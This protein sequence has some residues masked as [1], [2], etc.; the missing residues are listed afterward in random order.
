MNMIKIVFL[1]LVVL[2]FG[3]YFVSDSFAVNFRDSSGYTPSWAIDAGM[4]SALNTCLELSGDTSR[5]GNWCLEW[6]IYVLD[7]GADNFSM[8]N[9]SYNNFIPTEETTTNTNEV[10]SFVMDYPTGWHT[11]STAGTDT[12]AL[13]RAS[14]SIREEK[15]GAITVGKTIGKLPV[16][17]FSTLNAFTNSIENNCVNQ[18]DSK[19]DKF[20]LITSEIK[21]IN[22][23]PTYYVKYTSLASGIPTTFWIMSI[24]DGN[25]VWGVAAKSI[26]P[27]KWGS[28]IEESLETF[29]IITVSN[30]NAEIQNIS[31]N[32][33]ISSTSN[34]DTISIPVGTG[35]PGCE[36]NNRCY[37]PY[38][39]TISKGGTVTW[40]NDDTAAHTVT[41]GTPVEGPS[42]A[43]D[44]SLMMAGSTF[45]VTFDQSGE[46]PYF[47][48]VHPWMVGHIIV[49]TSTT[50]SKSTTTDT[51]TSTSV[52]KNQ[53]LETKSSIVQKLS[54]LLSNAGY[55][56]EDPT[57]VAVGDGIIKTG[58][59]VKDEFGESFGGINVW[60][61]NNYVT[62]VE[63]AT[64]HNNDFD[65]ASI[66]VIA[67]AG[68]VKTIMDPDDFDVDVFT[69]MYGE[70]ADDL[71]YD[72]NSVRT[73]SNGNRVEVNSI[74]ILE[75]V[76]GLTMVTFHVYYN[77]ENTST[78]LKTIQNTPEKTTT[79]SQKTIQTGEIKSE[80]S[81]SDD[82]ESN[83][84]DAALGAFIV[85]GIPAILIG[86]FIVRRKMKKSQER[87]AS[88]PKWKGV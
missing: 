27:V 28:A 55:T 43:F 36:T 22:Q 73:T 11:F 15:D 45:S 13:V 82:S 10:H 20:K 21:T 26:K 46:Y 7:Q 76:P 5:D 19:C 56:V 79:T 35:S 71:D 63:L 58:Y 49:G 30:S 3:S 12:L 60:T 9:E 54:S 42:G 40:S 48:M 44:S 6:T 61:K 59:I 34:S 50:T 52:T 86:L 32:T 17:D 37:L 74:T 4:Y 68:M 24:P 72:T 88:E 29:R 16:N 39:T 23:K 53:Q 64:S 1:A 70:A 18:D 65:S 83:A 57:P 33:S 75:G 77:L 85:L 66:A 84:G 25:Q 14:D 78:E 80:Q 2:V 69:K 8:E 62:E 47:C 87:K 41:S 31:T 67:L 38:S 81:T 51:Q